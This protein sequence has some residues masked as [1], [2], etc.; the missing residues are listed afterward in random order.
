MRT[1]LK[2][3]ALLFISLGSGSPALAMDSD[4]QITIS[5]YVCA[6]LETAAEGKRYARAIHHEMFFDD[7]DGL[8][9]Q[10][11]RAN[12]EYLAVKVN[13]LQGYSSFNKD[14]G[15]VIVYDPARSVVNSWS[16]TASSTLEV[17]VTWK[18]STTSGNKI[19]VVTIDRFG[20]KLHEEDFL[21]GTGPFWTHDPRHPNAED[22]Q[23][24]RAESPW[25]KDPHKYLGHLILRVAVPVDGPQPPADCPA[26]DVECR[27]EWAKDRGWPCVCNQPDPNLAICSPVIGGGGGGGRK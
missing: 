20:N 21:E 10:R 14:T 15:W 9:N 2:I 12:D 19:R 13:G 17:S 24:T 5:C 22:Y 18:T 11:Y 16:I 1:I 26:T 3:A 27:L 25:W 23:Y 7:P 4:E 8:L 6:R